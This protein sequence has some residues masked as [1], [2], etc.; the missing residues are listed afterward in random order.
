M[1]ILVFNINFIYL[2]EKYCYPYLND[3]ETKV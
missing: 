3:E 1:E 2:W